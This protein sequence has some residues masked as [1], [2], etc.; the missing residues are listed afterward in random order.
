MTAAAVGPGPSGH[1]PSAPVGPVLDPRTWRALHGVTLAVAAVVLLVANRGQWFF[2]DDFEFLTRRTGQ[3]NGGSIWEPHN[4][5]WSTLPVLAYQALFAV[6]H[7][8]TYW[9]WVVLLIAVHLTTVHLAWRLSQHA[10]A[11][12][13][14]AAVTAVITSVLGSGAENLLWG[15]QIGF[16]GSVTGVLG[17]TL[18]LDRE[19]LT[20]GRLVAGWAL[21]VAALMCS[22]VAI[23]LL[24]LPGVVSL[25]RHGVGR[26]VA[27]FAVPV[28]AYAT[29][30]LTAGGSSTNAPR[31]TAA[32]YLRY[33]AA[34][35]RDA[36]SSI[37]G[38]RFGPVL[39][40]AALAG[41]TVLVVR[42]RGLLPR[43]A[44]AV[45]VGA[46]LAVLAQYASIAI[47]RSTLGT[48][49]AGESRYVYLA[50][51]TGAPLVAGLAGVLLRWRP[52]L[53]A[54][55]LAA[56]A[57][58]VALH[59]V[60]DL[61]DRAAFERAREQAGRS[62]IAATLVLLRDR[63][64]VLDAVAYPESGYTGTHAI[65][66]LQSRGDFGSTLRGA[67]PEVVAAQRLRVQFALTRGPAPG[68]A[69]AL[70]VAAA[71]GTTG[72]ATGSC[73][74]Y[75]LTGGGRAQVLLDASGGAGS[76]TVRAPHSGAATVEY[77]PRHGEPVAS[78]SVTVVVY[79]G[80]P[81]TLTWEGR[82]GTVRVSF[83]GG[84]PTSVCR[85][86][87]TPAA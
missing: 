74:A 32:Q 24:V 14:V 57:L 47:G 61:A 7:L 54:L 39:L 37:G 21:L 35:L 17:A 43:P 15:F 46:S 87:A 76:V 2:K 8:T 30:Y 38:T 29:W 18:V 66:F 49:Q 42:D 48:A 51:L 9:P 53:A 64:P 86:G 59:N 12:Q 20:T 71:P 5:H 82:V 27:V 72:T 83:P 65:A 75:S 78:A 67:A 22:G 50:A 19:R 28:A 84:G 79:A 73:T 58:Y 45:M 3:P 33:L 62:D 34:G 10:Q 23:P 36:G 80:T 63:E 60:T 52:R 16:V 1:D 11:G 70:R 40:A 69:A 55:P 44:G 4:A 77:L 25:V 26:T 13:A 6:F 68:G 31:P 41:V 81:E 56:L 85:P